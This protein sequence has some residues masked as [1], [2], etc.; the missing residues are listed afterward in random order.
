MRIKDKVVNT[1]INFFNAK[2]PT[3]QVMF[4]DV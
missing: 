2:M 1:K 3:E 4:R